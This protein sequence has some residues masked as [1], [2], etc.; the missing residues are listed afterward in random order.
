MDDRTLLRRTWQTMGVILLVGVGWDSAEKLGCWGED[1]AALGTDEPDPKTA[2]IHAQ[3]RTN[4]AHSIES[5]TINEKALEE[6]RLPTTAGP[7][8]WMRAKIKNK[9]LKRV[10][11][12]DFRNTKITDEELKELT[13]FPNLKGI[14]LDY[15]VKW[16]YT[17]TDE[18]V[19]EL[20]KAMP[21]LKINEYRDAP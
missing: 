6:L 9:D 20:K 1:E 15:G 21:N 14:A 17:V 4:N 16:N 12:L 5:R 7:Y 8:K 18:A 11:Y 3:I 19:A 2:E 10:T 13:K